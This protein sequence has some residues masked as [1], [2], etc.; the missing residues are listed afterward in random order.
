MTALTA[1]G[2]DRTRFL[3][4]ALRG[5]ALFSGIS[6][7]AAAAFAGLLAEFMG[8]GWPVIFVVLGIGL[9]AFA[10]YLWWRT[11]RPTIDLGEAWTIVALDTAWV[12]G[13]AVL[14]LA[15]PTLLSPAG[16]WVVALTAVAVADIALI[17]YLGIRGARRAAAA[18]HQA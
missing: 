3:R 6:G 1:L 5:N 8:I 11:S 10:G 9:I 14:L 4:R 15:A 13:S 18:P 7:L 17:E 16:E 2:P 12:A